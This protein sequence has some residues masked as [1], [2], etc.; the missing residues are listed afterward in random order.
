MTHLQ[1][2]TLPESQKLTVQF[3]NQNPLPSI[4]HH[5]L[6]FYSMYIPL[7]NTLFGFSCVLFFC[8]FFFYNIM[9]HLRFI[10]I[11]MCNDSSFYYS[12]IYYLYIWIFF[13]HLVLYFLYVPC[14][15]FLLSSPFLSSFWLRFLNFY[16]LTLFFLSTCLEIMQSIAI[17]LAITLV[18]FNYNNLKHFN[19]NHPF[20][21]I[22]FFCF[23][24][25]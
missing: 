21:Q 16:F 23:T 15:L 8:N 17:L 14:F 2:R 4:G 6:A 13:C 10:Y 25:L 5:V 9:I 11:D 7:N 18:I 22:I 24:I 3:P 20:P 1:T 12:I 19:S